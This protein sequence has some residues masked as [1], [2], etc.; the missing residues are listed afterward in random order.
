VTEEREV[1]MYPFDPL[2]WMRGS[3]SEDGLYGVAAFRVVMSHGVDKDQ[4]CWVKT[5]IIVAN[6]DVSMRSVGF[7]RFS[8]TYLG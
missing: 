6:Q 3:L 2:E 5:V 8:T 4:T 7:G 1:W